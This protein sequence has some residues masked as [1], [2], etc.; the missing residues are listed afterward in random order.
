MKIGITGATGF[1]AGELIPRLA[2]R[3]HECV[4]F[5]RSANRA[6]TGCLETRA[7]GTGV[8]PDLSGLDACVNLAG[9]SV[10]GRWTAAKKRRIRESRLEVTR[11]LVDAMKSSPVRV[12]DQRLRLGILR[13][14]GR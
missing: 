6:V 10:L 11:A 3:G 1:I 12:L 2:E 14:A 7:L 13:R 9:E 8:T 5:S 4:A